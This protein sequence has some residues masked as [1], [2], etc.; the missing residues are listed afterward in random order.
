MSQYIQNAEDVK[1]RLMPFGIFFEKS[2][3]D[4]IK[5]IRSHNDTPEMLQTFLEGVLAE[6]REEVH[7]LDLNMKT[8]AVLKLTYLEMYGF[9][10]SWANFHILEVMSSTKLQQKRVG[11]LAAS[12]SFYKD[13]DILMLATNLMRKDLNYSGANDIVKVGIALSGLSTIITPSLASH[14]CNDLFLMLTSQKSY[15]KKK[16]VSALFKVFLQYPEALRD[17]FERFTS[18]LEDE[19]MSVLSAVISVIC[20]LSKKNPEPF[21]PLSPLLYE[22]LVTIDNNWIIIRLLKLFTNLARFEKKLRPKLLPKVLELMDSTSATSVLY[23]S[24]NCIV[25]GNILKEDDYDTAFQCLERL[26]TFCDSQDPNLRYIS[27]GLFYKIGKINTNFISR[28]DSLV[29]RLV[30]DI[31]V[32]IRSKAIELL[33][34]ITVNDN[35]KDIVKTLIKQFVESDKF[36]ANNNSTNY[37][38]SNKS[39][40]FIPEDYNVKVINAIIKICSLDNF[41]N[42]SDFEWYSAVLVDLS[43]L[44]QDISDKS[45]GS[46]IGEQLKNI[47]IRVPSM[48]GFTISTI[49]S[50]IS[51][52]DIS[53]KLPS[54][55]E[56]CFW[57]LGE[58]SSFIDNGNDLIRFLINQGNHYSPSI[59]QVLLTCMIKIFSN[60]SNSHTEEAQ[61]IK[62]ILEEL[63]NFLETFSFSTH[64]ELQERGIEY[65]EFLKLSVEAIS[66]TSA[67]LPLLITEVLPS[68]FNSNELKPIPLHTQKRLNKTIAIDLDTPFLTESE[69]QGICDG[70]HYDKT[71]DI[72]SIFSN[73]SIESESNN[74]DVHRNNGPSSDLNKYNQGMDAT[75]DI[76]SQLRLKYTAEDESRKSNLFYLDNEDANTNRKKENLLDFDDSKASNTSSTFNIKTIPS[77]GNKKK[78]RKKHRVHVLSDEL[79]FELFPNTTNTKETTGIKSSKSNTSKDIINLNTNSRL[80]S[81][82]FSKLAN[83]D[84]IHDAELN[85]LRKKFSDN[86][87]DIHTETNGD[88]TDVEEVIIIKKKKKSSKKSHSKKKKNEIVIPDK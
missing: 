18:L 38:T 82:N 80:E 87:I 26:N 9:D 69:L 29:I 88:V 49:V 67:G 48:R 28:Y 32:S 31:D 46:K 45:L 10:M 8:N 22:L 30:S 74:E 39:F 15:I 54:I 66:G 79:V 12:Q 85:E 14:I 83:S 37:E 47:M 77:V 76:N 13:T 35:V 58:F 53:L 55:L 75:S 36:V 70:E 44:S 2:L 63:I 81:F 20:E 6:C 73:D 60:W 19:D 40:V 72:N 27:C 56:D 4:L 65:T 59:Q 3:K 61:E 41:A 11:Y 51:N 78:D 62:D 43:V 84:E 68:L 86:L 64:F 16:A 1:K 24:I 34:G 5:G 71:E 21:I 50:I 25:R 57:V 42:I 33:E 7:V 23:E 17:N 52:K